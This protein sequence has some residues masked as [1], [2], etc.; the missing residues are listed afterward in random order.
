LIH[1]IIWPANRRVLDNEK[2][3]DVEFHRKILKN[4]DFVYWDSMPKRVEL[5]GPL[6]GYIYIDGKVQYKCIID[7][8]ISNENL[9]KKIDDHK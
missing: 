8:V 9:R 2:E 3:A 5:K 7:E 6:A 1:A 4:Q